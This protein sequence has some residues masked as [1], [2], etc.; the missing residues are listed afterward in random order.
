MYLQLHEKKETI[1]AHMQKPFYKRTRRR[2]EKHLEAIAWSSGQTMSYQS[3]Q[4]PRPR[5]TSDMEHN[6]QEETNKTGIGYKNQKTR[7]VQGCLGEK[8]STEWNSPPG[9]TQASK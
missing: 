6:E 1:G 5:P 7:T 2:N 8:T 4:L 3:E 9:P